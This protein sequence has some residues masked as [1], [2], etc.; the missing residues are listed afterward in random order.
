MRDHL[1]Y[2]RIMLKEHLYSY[3]GVVLIIAL[4]LTGCEFPVADKSSMA[5]AISTPTSEE[6][7]IE[8]TL[9]PTVSIPVYG[10]DD[11]PTGVN[12]L[13]GMVVD[14]PDL[15]DR[16]PMLVKVSNYPRSG[17]PHAGLS[18]ADLVFDY[19]IGEGMN[20]FVGLYYGR[21]AI[22][23]GP[24]RSG[25]TGGCPACHSIPWHPG[26]QGSLV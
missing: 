25:Q 20:R 23:V 13:T 7:I 5:V 14:D 17:R 26:I 3:M 8:P 22:K 2:N 16:C 19:Y 24:I 21:D 6:I 12:P 18:M 11:Y 4:L 10:P 9:T 15:L 1:G